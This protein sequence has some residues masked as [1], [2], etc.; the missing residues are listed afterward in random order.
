MSKNIP[1]QMEEDLQAVLQQE[2]K[3]K[4]AAARERAEVKTAKAKANVLADDL[5]DTLTTSKIKINGKRGLEIMTRMAA[6]RMG[7]ASGGG[8]ART[9]TEHED[10]IDFS[11]KLKW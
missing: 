5:V 1:Q 11:K 10:S 7:L 8:Y 9:L 4:L 2:Y 6:R 3:D